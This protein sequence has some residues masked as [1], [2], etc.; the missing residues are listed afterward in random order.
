MKF[1]TTRWFVLVLTLLGGAAGYG[2]FLWAEAISQPAQLYGNSLIS[3]AFGL[4]LGFFGGLKVRDSVLKKI[5]RG[6]EQEK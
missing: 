3:L 2:Y 6:E 1:L 5:R 4:G